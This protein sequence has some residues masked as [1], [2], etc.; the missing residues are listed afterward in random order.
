MNAHN[1]KGPIKRN[2]VALQPP[3]KPLFTAMNQ[4]NDMGI[5]V[6][7]ITADDYNKKTGITQYRL[8][9]ILK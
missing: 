3:L 7:N 5:I 2:V 9:L 4:V 1:S 6:L 8:A